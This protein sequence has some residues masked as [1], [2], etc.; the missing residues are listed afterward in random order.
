MNSIRETGRLMPKTSS[1]ADLRSLIDEAAA[2]IAA[3][4]EAT[5]DASMDATT[6]ESNSRS[7][8]PKQIFDGPT[9]NGKQC[10]EC[11]RKY[12]TGAEYLTCRLC[13][14]VVCRR[15]GTCKHVHHATHRTEYLKSQK[16]A[17]ASQ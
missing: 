12:K 11:K 14:S 10:A 6:H 17:E 15:K 16:R 7:G 8:L 2:N 1:T 4:H 5:V 9:F 13:K 3:R